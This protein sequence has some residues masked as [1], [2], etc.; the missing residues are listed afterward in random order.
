SLPTPG[1]QCLGAH[2][3]RFAA[4]P[5]A[6]PPSPAA[7]YAEARRFLAP[8]R[9]VSPAGREGRLPLRHAFLEITSEPPGG[10]VLS[11]LK[12]ADER[13]ALI[14]RLFNPGA[15]SVRVRVAAPEPLVA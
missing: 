1:A 2:T 7:L 11:A 9:L 13:E 10:V 12:R 14:V 6:A 5:R 4:I 8:P 15:D 3:L